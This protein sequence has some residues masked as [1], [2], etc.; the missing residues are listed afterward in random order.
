MSLRSS[1]IGI[2]LQQI[3]QHFLNRHQHSS[4]ARRGCRLRHLRHLRQPLGFQRVEEF[5]RAAPHLLAFLL[6]KFGTRPPEDIA[7]C[8]L[9][10]A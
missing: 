2:F 6:R 1:F 3:F 7:E 8:Q 10:V 4:A 5:A 9:F